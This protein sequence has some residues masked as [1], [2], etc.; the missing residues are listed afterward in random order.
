MSVHSSQNVD[1][2]VALISDVHAN[3]PAL[4]AVIADVEAEGVTRVWCLGDL[5]GYGAS[6]DECV[7]L[8]AEHFELCLIGNHDL[9]A[10]G[11]L[12]IGEFSPAAATAA[13]W[14]RERLG[15]DAVSYLDGLGSQDSVGPVGLWHAS[16]RDAVW[17]YVLSTLS[18]GGCMDAMSTRIGAVGH[19]HVALW[20]CRHAGDGLPE[21]EPA[22]AG[23]VRDLSTGTWLLNPGAV[24]QPRDGDPRAA[25]LM[26]DLDGPRAVWHRVAYGIGEAATAI[27]DAGLPAS[28]AE[29]LYY[30]Q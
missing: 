18:A 12:D 9:A 1:R 11:R 6:P 24:G 22:A 28:L 27:R 23:T 15:E 16:P 10:L 17:E 5:V 29:R 3:L 19:S 30:G 8:A 14:T 2:R 7:A 26:L 4:R 20:F 25:W 13:V 21:G